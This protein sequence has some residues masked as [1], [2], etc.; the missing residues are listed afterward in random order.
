MG[1]L[2]ARCRPDS[3]VPA[4][5]VEAVRAEPVPQLPLTALERMLAPYDCDQA[6]LG[7]W[8]DLVGSAR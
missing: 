5:A 4:G 1:R 2:T 8:I 3:V 7:S 6:A